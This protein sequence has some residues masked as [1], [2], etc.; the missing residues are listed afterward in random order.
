MKKILSLLFSLSLTF[1]LCQKIELKKVIDCSQIFKGKI[2]GNPVTM[3]LSYDGII[4][5]HQY[6]HFV[7]GWYY[8]DK[9]KKKI[10]L[11]GVYDLAN[12]HLYNFGSQQDK[13]F[14]NFEI[15]H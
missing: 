14:K 1:L 3:Q 9:Y 6:Q 13:K 7:K 15:Q 5:C 11:T 8:Y 2:A 4:D 12:L 10:P